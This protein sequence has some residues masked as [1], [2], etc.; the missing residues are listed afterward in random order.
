MDDTFRKIIAAGILG[1]LVYGGFVLFTHFKEFE[2]QEKAGVGSDYTKTEEQKARE[3]TAGPLPG[4]PH[5]YEKSLEQAKAA[6][7]EEVEKW[8]RTFGRYCKDPR[9]AEIE[10]DYAATIVRTDLDKAK[11][12]FDG[13]RKRTP[14]DSPLFPRIKSLEAAYQ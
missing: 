1:L 4:L 9:R 13:V 7:P 12:V 14:A 2:K 5:Q 10:L 8:L 3:A 6:G 11:Q